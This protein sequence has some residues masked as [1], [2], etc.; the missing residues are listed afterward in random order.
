MQYFLT[1]LSLLLWKNRL[2]SY[3]E[4]RKQDFDNLWSVGES[5]TKNGPE[6]HL[7]LFKK[8]DEKLTKMG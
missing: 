1:T 6:L 3:C 5:W 7:K 8:M 2:I 4:A